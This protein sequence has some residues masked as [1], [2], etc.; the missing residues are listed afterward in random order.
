MQLHE[1]L[2]GMSSENKLLAALPECEWIRLRRYLSPLE[3]P[4]GKTL[5]EPHSRLEYAYFPVSAIISLLH[6]AADGA[7]TEIAMIGNEGLAGV[8]LIMGSGTTTSRIM[9]QSKGQIYRLKSDVLRE[10]FGRGGA[11]QQLLLR[12][13]NALLTQISQAAVCNRR[14]SIDQQLCR[15]LLLSLDR[16]GSDELTM[17]HEVLANTL[18]VRREGITEAAR[19]LHNAGLINYRRGRITVIERSGVEAYCCE[20]YGVVRREYDRLPGPYAYSLRGAPLAVANRAAPANGFTR[21]D[22]SLAI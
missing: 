22:R 2:G 16:L 8:S 21:I 9:V 3:A 14:H 13:T 17:T 1:N 7:S 10:E 5:C 11:L 6:V 15:W 12:F 18:G 19:K 4:A 20:C